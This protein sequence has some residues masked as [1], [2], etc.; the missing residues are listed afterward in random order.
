M[1][2]KLNV[3]DTR[4]RTILLEALSLNVSNRYGG[5]N[6]QRTVGVEVGTE[7]FNVK[8]KG[9]KGQPLLQSTSSTMTGEL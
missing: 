4:D 2:H 6:L 7:I 8:P 5:G 9:S 1:D 3:I